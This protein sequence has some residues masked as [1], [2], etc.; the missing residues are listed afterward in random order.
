MR[1]ACADVGMFDMSRYAEVITIVVAH[2]DLPVSSG[3]QGRCEEESSES[4]VDGWHDHG[5]YRQLVTLMCDGL[6][7]RAWATRVCDR[8]M[9]LMK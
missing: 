9:G 2:L 4:S 5:R 8:M 1:E 7:A 6:V 3:P